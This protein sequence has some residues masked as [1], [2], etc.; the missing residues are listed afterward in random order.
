M[1]FLI[2][3]YKWKGTMCTS[4]VYGNNPFELESDIVEVWFSEFTSP[5][6]STIAMLNDL[7]RCYGMKRYVKLYVYQ[8]GHHK[9]SS[10]F[11]TLFLF[12]EL[13]FHQFK[14]YQIVYI[15][16]LRWYINV[17]QILA[18]LNDHLQFFIHFFILWRNIKFYPSF[19]ICSDFFPC[20][21]TRNASWLI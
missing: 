12:V 16:S 18:T 11:C 5:C 4:R 17:K 19:K 9:L 3:V 10:F 2:R 1:L 6:E 13:K 21:N 15:T 14:I 8:K 20:K 7:L